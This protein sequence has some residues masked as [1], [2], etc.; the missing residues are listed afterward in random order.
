LILISGDIRQ[1]ARVAI[2][3]CPVDGQSLPKLSEVIYDTQPNIKRE[4]PFSY[5]ELVGRTRRKPIP[6]G[7]GSSLQRLNKILNEQL[8]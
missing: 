7:M 3:Q 8:A 6:F 4:F 2:T 1:F 5:G